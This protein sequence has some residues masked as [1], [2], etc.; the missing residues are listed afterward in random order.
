M[1]GNTIEDA[2]EIA[3]VLRQA[4]PNLCY[5]TVTHRENNRTRIL[6]SDRMG[7]YTHRVFCRRGFWVEG[8]LGMWV[9][10]TDPILK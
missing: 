6:G 3:V 1:S 7:E 4:Q 8:H 9:E 5:P 10:V 2:L